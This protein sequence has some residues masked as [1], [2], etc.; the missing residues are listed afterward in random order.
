[1]AHLVTIMVIIVPIVITFGWMLS[2]RSRT[3]RVAKLL[4]QIFE[5]P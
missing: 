5:E 1:M 2:D 4:D 3:K